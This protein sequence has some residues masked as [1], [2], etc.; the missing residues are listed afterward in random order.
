MQIRALLSSATNIALDLLYPPRCGGCDRR[1]TLFC[2]QC[3]R[4]VVIPTDPPEHIQHIDVVA[5]AGIFEG[6]L[7]QAIHKLKYEGD[8]PLAKPLAALLSETLLRD[9][10]LP[11]DDGDPPRQ[12]V[13]VPVP[14]H[15][16]RYAERGFNQSEL[17]ARE[18]SR[19]TGWQL[20]H[21]LERVKPTRSQVGL[22]E[23]ERTENVKGAFACKSSLLPAQIT[24][25]DDVCTTGATLSECAAVLRASGVQKVQ[26]LTV[27]KAL[28]T[29]M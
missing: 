10:F 25:I 6:P 27:G 13:L 2:E 4:A 23:R 1:G 29:N 24:L 7:R 12:P 17:L 3:W 18:L 8:T 19:V 16:K 21:A 9:G 26:A 11:Q 14:L 15:P 28:N 22:S 5:S 20:L